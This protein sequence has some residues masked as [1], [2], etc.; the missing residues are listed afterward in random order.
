MMQGRVEDGNIDG[1]GRLLTKIELVPGMR[2]RVSGDA[3]RLSFIGMLERVWVRKY[4]VDGVTYSIDWNEPPTV[5]A[6]ENGLPTHYAP[7][8][9]AEA[10]QYAARVVAENQ[11]R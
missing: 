4:R 9:S 2:V 3:E 7:S 10:R 8:L 6:L 5:P 11:R 1:C